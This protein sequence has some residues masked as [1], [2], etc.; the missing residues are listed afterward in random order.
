MR[1]QGKI[2]LVTGA[3]RGIGRAIALGLAEEGARVMV[4]C[5]QAGEAAQQVVD[6]IQAKGG[7][8]VAIQADVAYKADR[9]R[10]VQETAHQFG[11]I[12]VLVNSA[13]II[14]WHNV[15]DSTEEEWDRQFNVNAK[16]LFFLSL[17]AAR[18]MAKT[19]GGSI[20][21]VCSVAG[22]RARNQ[23]SIYAISKAAACMV[24]QELALEL[25]PSRVRVNGILPATTE[26]DLNRE[27]LKAPGAKQGEI[28]AT[29]LGRLGTTSDIV[30]AAVFL[31]SE[32]ASWITG[33]LLPIDGGIS[34]V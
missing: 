23:I 12:D 33:V 7:S 5:R 29:P 2:A 30:G 16:G 17:D 26:T 22:I 19:G 9:K 25:A 8:A 6:E 4:V 1:L 20:V 31:A 32:E 13:G 28:E 27:H 11:R 15:F 34:V 24:T 3:S 21:N 14:S 18:E 10:L